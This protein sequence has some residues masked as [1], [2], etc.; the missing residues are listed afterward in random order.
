MIRSQLYRH[1]K[2]QR[3]TYGNYSKEAIASVDHVYQQEHP[4]DW[5]CDWDAFVLEDFR[6][7]STISSCF[8]EESVS[9]PGN[10]AAIFR[11]SA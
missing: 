8:V 6:L 1:F 10:A 2:D 5:D 3:S 7:T 11:K 4:P 9:I